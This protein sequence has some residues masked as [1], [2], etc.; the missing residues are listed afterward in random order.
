MNSETIESEHRQ[1]LNSYYGISRHF[2]DWTRKYYL[3]GRD[4]ALSALLS[5]DWYSLLEIG[6]GTGRNLVKL[7]RD[8]PNCRYFGLEASDEMLSHARSKCGFAQL[9]HGFAESTDLAQA[10]G[11]RPDRILFSYCL[12]MTLNPERAIENAIAAVAPGGQVVVVDFGSSQGLPHWFRSSLK[13]WLNAF[14]VE[15]LDQ[16]QCRAWGGSVKEALGGYVLH[17][18]FAKE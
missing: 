8:R 6:P 2:Y 4:P 16:G 7:Y 10:C 15:P 14:H 17:A 1:F 9:I 11:T 18:R 5:E 12:S 3:L 13:R